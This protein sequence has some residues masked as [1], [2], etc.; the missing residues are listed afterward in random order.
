MCIAQSDFLSHPKNKAQLVTLCPTI[1][2]KLGYLEGWLT[3]R[4]Y[5]C[6]DSL[7]NGQIRKEHDGCSFRQGHFGRVCRQCQRRNI[8]QN[9]NSW[10]NYVIWKDFRDIRY[11]PDSLSLND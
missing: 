2:K 4:Y 1:L 6:K 3:L 11:S 10:L 9:V 7:G 5:D 8:N